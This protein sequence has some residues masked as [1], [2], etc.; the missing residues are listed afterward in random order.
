MYLNLFEVQ[1]SW[2]PGFQHDFYPFFFVFWLNKYFWLPR[3]GA[4]LRAVWS[5]LDRQRSSGPGNDTRVM[6]CRPLLWRRVPLENWWRE[7][8]YR[9]NT[10]AQKQMHQNFWFINFDQAFIDCVELQS[11]LVEILQFFRSWPAWITSRSAC[12]PLITWSFRWVCLLRKYQCWTSMASC[13]MYKLRFDL[14][15]F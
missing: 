1:L 12:A 15:K 11:E 2:N 10:F 6:R 8:R 13:S 14:T 5:R 9:Q 7:H 3:G 4:W